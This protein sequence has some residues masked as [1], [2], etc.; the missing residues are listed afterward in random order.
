MAIL[1][2]SFD[3]VFHYRCRSHSTFFKPITLKFQAH[4]S[5]VLCIWNLSKD[6]LSP[7]SHDCSMHCVEDIAMARAKNL[8]IEQQAEA[9]ASHC[10]TKPMCLAQ[11]SLSCN[12]MGD[13]SQAGPKIQT[14]QKTIYIHLPL[15]QK[16]FPLS[17][18]KISD[19]A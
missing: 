5:K 19:S 3:L 12:G 7:S 14:S 8:K 10:L 17:S 15:H 16:K 13:Q 2:F 4:D 6:K 1:S 9:M 11:R 18:L